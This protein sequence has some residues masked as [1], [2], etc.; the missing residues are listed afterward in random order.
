F[1]LFDTPGAYSFAF[2][3]NDGVRLEIGDYMVIED[4]DVHA[5]RFSDIGAVIVKEPGWHPITIRYF[6]RKNTATLRF[7]WQPPGTSGTM[8]VVPPEALAH[9]P[10]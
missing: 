3:S 8:P 1:I 7:Y 10:R 5:D 6:E 2:E 4:P 9:L